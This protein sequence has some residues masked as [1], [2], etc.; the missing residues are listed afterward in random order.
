[1]KKVIV[2][3]GQSLYTLPP[4]GNSEQKGPLYLATVAI[5][6]KDEEF[7]DTFLRL[8]KFNKYDVIFLDIIYQYI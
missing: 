3:I 6:P 5:T 1:M 2:K 7:R 8:Y 4:L